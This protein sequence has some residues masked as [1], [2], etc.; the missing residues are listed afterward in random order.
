MT[1]Q[2]AD[3]HVRRQLRTLQRIV[4][5]PTDSALARRS[6]IAPA[7]FSEVMSGKRRP[8]EKF[9]AKVISGCLVYARAGGQMALGERDLLEALRLPGHRACLMWS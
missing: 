4:G 8:R 9:V 1:Y 7:T 3:D 2:H 6:G 5:N